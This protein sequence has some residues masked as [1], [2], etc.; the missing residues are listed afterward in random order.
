M[1]DT[2][3]PRKDESSNRSQKTP[4]CEDK[5]VAV[6]RNN[7]NSS[8]TKKKKCWFSE[9]PEIDIY[10]SDP[11]SP[12]PISIDDIKSVSQKYHQRMV[13]KEIASQSRRE[14]AER[15]E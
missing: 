9:I 7:N 15:A 5:N 1:S 4:N 13:E 10:D 11:P 6:A 8:S 3:S 12:K 2:S 14:L